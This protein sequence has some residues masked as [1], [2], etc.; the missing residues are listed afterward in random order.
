MKVQSGGSASQMAT[1]NACFCVEQMKVHLT[2]SRKSYAKNERRNEKTKTKLTDCLIAM[3]NC[4]VKDINFETT[5]ELL[6]TGLQSMGRL[7]EKWRKMVLFFQMVSNIIDTCLKTSLN[8]FVKTASKP[9]PPNMKYSSKM[10]LK[11][12]IYQQAFKA[13]DIANMVNMIS[14]TYTEISTLYLM[15][16][17]SSLGRLM[18]LDPEDPSFQRERTILAT[19]CD[20]AAAEIQKCVLENKENYKAK[21]KARIYKI[22]R[23]LNAALPPPSEEE[24]RETREIVAAGFE[25]DPE[26]EDQF[27]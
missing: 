11:D 24:T 16:R 12:M 10:F 26:D 14:E 2:Q 13:S 23:E 1:K 3:R 5:I 9:S 22:E 20:N 18:T 6:A 21:T 8:D 15:D 4:K 19:S 25:I 17:V 27:C 7:Q